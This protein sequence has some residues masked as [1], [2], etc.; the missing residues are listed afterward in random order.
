MTNRHTKETYFYFLNYYLFERRLFIHHTI[1]QTI[2]DNI[3]QQRKVHDRV[4]WQA[5]TG[6]PLDKNNRFAKSPL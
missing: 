2:I 4:D 5:L 6:Y 3:K 1:E